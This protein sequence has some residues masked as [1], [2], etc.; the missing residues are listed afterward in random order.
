MT[1]DSPQLKGALFGF[2]RASVRQLLAGRETMFRF[3]Q[4]RAQA[5]EAKV[6]E[7]QGELK[8]AQVQLLVQTEAAE[9]AHAET[10]AELREATEALREQTE[11]AAAVDAAL[12]EL[13]N[14]LAASRRAA[15]RL[16]D[17]ERKL[18]GMQIE[19][20]TARTEVSARTEQARSAEARVRDLQAELEVAQA[21]LDDRAEEART[22]RTTEAEDLTLMLNAAERGVT[23]IMERARH[24]YEAELA[25]AERV[26]ETIQADVER[27]G[28][29]QGNVEPLIRSV[30]EGIETARGRIIR[31]PDQI[32]E[33]VDSMTEAMMAVSDSLERLA[34][35]PGPL[36]EDPSPETQATSL[37]SPAE[38]V[39]QLKDDE[40][41]SPGTVVLPPDG[42]KNEH[43]KADS[44]ER[45]S[46]WAEPDDPEQAPEQSERTPS[47]PFDGTQSSEPPVERMYR[48]SMRPSDET[49]R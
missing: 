19:V 32:R 44:P 36:Y 14:E 39:I 28:D 23:G 40:P 5:A 37:D 25:Q 27:F 26:K 31:I 9:S 16:A 29:W 47:E 48:A 41:D 7:L 46:D 49:S 20:E 24:A 42:W 43:R 4:E 3:A 13:Q 1:S 17:A 18:T 30:Q 34:T 15:E 35:L 12:G 2:R 33:A 10:R 38:T 45:T 8:S 11:R 21:R 22:T 6:E